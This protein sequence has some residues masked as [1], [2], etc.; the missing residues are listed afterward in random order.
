MVTFFIPL[1]IGSDWQNNELRYLLRSLEKNFAEEFR[2]VVY[3]ETGYNVDWL[4]GVEYKKF[5]RYYPA[6]LLKRNHG[7]RSYENYFAVLDKVHQFVFSPDC[8]DKFVYIYDDILLIKKIDING[9]L[10]I[11]ECKYTFKLANHQI[12]NKHG[13]TVNQ[14]FNMCKPRYRFEHHLPLVYERDKLKEMF[15]IYRFQ[16]LIEPYALATLYFNLYGCDDLM[17]SLKEKLDY[18]A[19]FEGDF[20]QAVGCYSSSSKESINKAVDGKTWINY[21]DTGLF[22][23]PPSFPLQIWIKNKFPNQ[24]KYELC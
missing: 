15:T 24:S 19:G 13:R 9:I 1:G 14:A 3:G 20:A 7:N 5:D 4:T 21:N 22:W 10:N 11:P 6:R 16:D 12:H 18:K 17:G 23:G 2:I 8:P